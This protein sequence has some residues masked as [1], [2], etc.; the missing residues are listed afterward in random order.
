MRRAVVVA[1]G[2]GAIITSAAAFSI[3]GAETSAPL[4]FEGYVSALR[5][6]DAAHD[7]RIARCDLATGFERE[8]CRIETD[9]EQSVRRAD[10]EAAFRRTQHSARAAQRAHIEAR[11]QVE[12]AKC[13]A[14]GGYKRDKCL[15][16]VH[17]TRGRSM[18]AA[19]APYGARF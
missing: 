19:A 10:A 9:S 13:A 17:A 18:L 1:L 4:T 11:Y 7:A 15:V 16:Q 3:G 5:T 2:T 12:R 14:L 6:I 8:F